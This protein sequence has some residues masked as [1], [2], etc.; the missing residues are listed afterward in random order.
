M[1]VPQTNSIHETRDV[2]WGKRMYFVL[3]DKGS[4]HAMDSVELV[5]NKA[6][7]LLYTMSTDGEDDAGKKRNLQVR[8]TMWIRD[9]STMRP[10]RRTQ[11]WAMMNG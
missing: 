3:V 11:K 1:Y 5:V 2:Q 8:W 7:V 9:W 4:I 10:S 6:K